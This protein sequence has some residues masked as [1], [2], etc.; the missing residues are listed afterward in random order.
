MIASTGEFSDFQEVVR[1]LGQKSK[2]YFLHDDGVSLTPRDY[3]NYLSRVSYQRRNKMNP[4]MLLSVVAVREWGMECAGLRGRAE[5]PGHRGHLRHV[6]R[7]EVHHH[8]VRQPLLQLPH[9]QLLEGGLHRAGGQGAAEGV[10]QGKAHSPPLQILYYRDTKA[11]DRIQIAVVDHN[12]VRIEQPIAL[13]SKWDYND[14]KYRANE[15][16][17]T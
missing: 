1:L 2:E 9:Q 13:D 6:P 8:R 15:K 17:H 11:L 12:G 7:E 14:Y 10:L 3:G 16:L 4:L 5:V